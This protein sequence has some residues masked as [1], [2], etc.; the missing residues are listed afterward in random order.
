VSTLYTCLQL[1]CLAAMWV[2]KSSKIGVLFPF[3][4]AGLA[5]IRVIIEKVGMFSK[6][7]LAILDADDD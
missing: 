7:E 5:P 4:I 1:V 3:L 6:D 2:L